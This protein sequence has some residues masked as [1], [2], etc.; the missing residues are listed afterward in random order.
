[1]NRLRNS[2][3][4]AEYINLGDTIYFNKPP[5]WTVKEAWIKWRDSKWEFDSI[6]TLLAAYSHSTR[7]NIIEAEIVTG[8]CSGNGLLLTSKNPVM[9]YKECGDQ[10]NSFDALLYYV[11]DET[12]TPSGFPYIRI[13]GFLRKKLAIPVFTLSRVL[14]RQMIKKKGRV[15]LFADIDFHEYPI[16]IIKIE[17]HGK[18]DRYV[19]GIS[20]LCHPKPGANDNASGAATLLWIAKK[21]LL[22]GKEGWQPRFGITLIWVPEYLGTFYALEERFVDPDKTIFAIN[23]DMVGGDPAVNGGSLNLIETSP[24]RPGLEESVVS[25]FLGEELASNRSW[26]GYS[27]VPKVPIVDN[28]LFEFGSDHDPLSSYGVPAVMINQWPDRFYHTNED[29]PEKLSPFMLETVGRTTLKSMEFISNLNEE[30]AEEYSRMAWSY[31]FKVLTRIYERNQDKI[32][33]GIQAFRTRLHLLNTD[34]YPAR[35]KSFMDEQ[36]DR[37]EVFAESLTHLNTK[38]PTERCF[39]NETYKPLYKYLPEWIVASLGKDLTAKWYDPKIRTLLVE[40]YRLARIGFK[41]D[42]IEE[43]LRGYYGLVDSKELCTVKDFIRELE[44]MNILR[45]KR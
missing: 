4:E 33:N 8:K 12:R 38:Y 17:M 5:G 27:N 24:S 30:N 13:P 3:I 16:P 44:K 34:S 11:E 39:D 35:I 18:L 36:L 10:L 14:A 28:A 15:E 9:L 37:M 22:L 29:S 7:G 42:E 1:M 21:L 20:H 40:F 19:I 43:Y 41:G 32:L 6:A 25:Y 26:A 45:I 31:M 23:L 2:G